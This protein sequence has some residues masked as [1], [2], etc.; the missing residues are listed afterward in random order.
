MATH[1]SILARR[2]P[3]AEEPAGYGSW[4]CKES[5]TT[6]VTARTQH[7]YGCKG[8]GLSPLPLW[9][10]SVTSNAAAS[11]NDCASRP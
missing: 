7:G 5:D 4:G 11:P 3:W 2:I 1:S 6:G 10:S 8:K 9:F